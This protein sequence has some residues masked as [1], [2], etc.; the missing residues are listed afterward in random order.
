MTQQRFLC[1]HGHFYQPPRENPWIEGIE[2][3][4]S[5]HPYHDWNERIHHEC[6]RPNTL[7]RVL[8]DQ[9][10]VVD[11]VNNF[12]T[13]NFNFGPTLLSW[14]ADKHP[15]TY[16][17]IL[18]ADKRSLEKH[19]GHGNAIAQ[20]YNH[21]ILPLANERDQAT[22][23]KWGIED[24]KRRFGR[25]PESMWLAETACNE[26]SLEVLVEAG[27]KYLI[28]APHQ[29]EAISP[30][31]HEQWTDVS[32]G[33]IDPKI[34]YRCFLKN[35]PEKFIDI[36]F[37][38]GPISKDIGFGDLISDAK[39]F[40][41]RLENAIV[42]DQQG[43]QLVHIAVDG[44]T[45]G[46]HKPFGERALGYLMQMEAG[47]RGFQLVNYGEYLEKNPPERRVHIKE[48]ENGEGTS[49]SCAHG[50]GRWK[51]HC[52]CRGDGPG[53]WNQHWRKPLRDALDWLR[54]EIVTQFETVG[55]EYLYDVWDARNDYIQVMLDRSVQNILEFFD[56]HSRR[57]LTKDEI[58]LCL[59][60]LEAQRNAMFMYT[61]CG[62]FFT[63]LSGIETV[64]VF[65]YAGRA[66][67]LAQE[68][69]QHHRTPL[70]YLEEEF[71]NRLSH[72]KSN[73]PHF[74]DGRGIYEKLVKPANTPAHEIA[75]HFAICSIFD[76][77]MQ[78]FYKHICYR[79]QTVYQRKESYGNLTIN[80]GRMQ[81]RS[82]ITLEEYDLVFIA[83][84]F[85]A[86]DFR[87]SVKP[88]SDDQEFEAMEKAF[89]DDLYS[90]HM[91]ELIRKIDDYFGET[92]YSLKD[93]FLEERL[94]IISNLTKGS[95]EKI[96]QMYEQLYE[97]NRRMNEIYR[98]INI[99]I[100]E[101]IR[102]AVMHTLSRR[103]QSSVHHIAEEHYNMKK[104]AS[105]S[106]II[107][108]GH[109]FNVDLKKGELAG[110]LSHE[111]IE[112]VKNFFEHLQEG[113]VIESLNILKIAR[114][115]G[116]NLEQG[117]VQVH[118]F[119]LLKRWRDDRESF[120]SITQGV[121]DRVF[122]LAWELKINPTEIVKD[123][124]AIHK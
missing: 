46:H 91:M 106:R 72:A 119:N 118:L 69:G 98:S 123:Y 30:L 49:W 28:L 4:E 1:I 39:Q 109:A 113:M 7:A 10:N 71:L 95:I 79:L 52:G 65:Q 57:P 89:F 43:N 83:I 116:V 5:A 88:F 112:R 61:S 80:F 25:D 97:E 40:M 58:I 12:E 18:E 19:N 35:Q 36:F 34:P 60:L 114:K 68:I 94:T 105:I 22:Q 111:L 64:Q 82:N 104:L 120:S 38:D 75:A 16:Q 85:G 103:L 86:Y 73:V 66:I 62:W 27:M 67:Q 3:Q 50:V 29:A 2:L 17:R 37:Y 6:Y 117:D 63:E 78:D 11:I 56:R 81:L 84:Q 21:M 70:P 9:G 45:Y 47:T 13:M 122:E 24:F 102:Y 100:P 42:H 54:D 44:E 15:E 59:K 110:F 76:G 41:D 121:R 48:G 77:F 32:Q 90:V 87:C 115:I 108:Q 14:M 53:D 51:D 107:E 31:A 20:V 55:G 96:S 93:L 74:G 33:Q 124:E 92:Y 101:E 8:D 99:P 26:K 23:V